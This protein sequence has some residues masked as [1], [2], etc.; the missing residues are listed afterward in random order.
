MRKRKVQSRAPR[1]S[2]HTWVYEDMRVLQSAWWRF[3]RERGPWYLRIGQLG[4][5]TVRCL[6]DILL[7]IRSY[8]A[9]GSSGATTPEPNGETIAGCVAR[10]QNS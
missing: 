5:E 2:V 9:S 1:S 6:L 8:V 10:P 7:S 3:C 4:R